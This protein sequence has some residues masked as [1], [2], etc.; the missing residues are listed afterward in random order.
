MNGDNKRLR[1]TITH[2]DF[3]LQLLAMFWFLRRIKRDR[4]LYNWH[5]YVVQLSYH[6]NCLAAFTS[7]L[8][9]ISRE[10]FKQTILIQ[11]KFSFESHQVQEYASNLS[12]DEREKARNSCSKNEWKQIFL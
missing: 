10:F 7:W 12:L 5:F 1:L 6:D 3:L 4:K 11:L 9:F 8:Y 2:L